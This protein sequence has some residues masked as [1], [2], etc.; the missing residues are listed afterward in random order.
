MSDR[1]PPEVILDIFLALERNEIEKC[2]LVSCFWKNTVNENASIFPL[3]LCNEIQI[4]NGLNDLNIY[5]YSKA[6]PLSDDTVKYLR[7]CAFNKIEISWLKEGTKVEDIFQ[8]LAKI[9]THPLKTRE[10]I[11]HN[12][13]EAY[14][15]ILE[16]YV[17]TETISFAFDISTEQF[18]DPSWLNFPKPPKKINLKIRDVELEKLLKFICNSEI[19]G[20][21]RFYI[22]TLPPNPLNFNDHR[23]VGKMFL[24]QFLQV[25][26]I[27]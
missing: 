21:D 18:E 6:F 7:Y 14:S 19:R 17:I 3:R 16:K 20:V 25:S 10:L 23:W 5:P 13:Y 4:N 24:E 26:L 22:E 12:Q 8:E 15:S 9:S 1:V 2:Q 11:C 27:I